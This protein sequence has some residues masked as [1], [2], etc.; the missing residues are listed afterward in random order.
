MKSLN[1]LF[2][3][4]ILANELDNNIAVAFQFSDPDGVRSGKSG[5]SFGVCQFDTRNN[6][7]ALKCLS[8]CGFT[9]DEIHGI[10]DQTINVKPFAARLKAHSDII[11]VYDEEQLSRC[12]Y[13]AMNF[14]AS[15]GLPV[16]D[17]GAILASADYVNQYGSQGDQFAAFVKGLNRPM[18]ASDVLTFKLDHTLYGKKC[19][20]DCHRRYDNLIKIMDANSLATG[21]T[22]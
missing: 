18:I 15:H 17:T 20:K 3:D 7:Q 14:Y 10:V 2:R 16:T 8:A 1:E 21:R 19:P 13:S 12:L 22:P 11:S 5:W 4:V 9:Q 6:D